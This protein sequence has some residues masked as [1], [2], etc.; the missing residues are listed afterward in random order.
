MLYLSR[1]PGEGIKIGDS[2]TVIVVR[3]PN[4]PS[5]IRLCIDSPVDFPVIKLEKAPHV[6]GVIASKDN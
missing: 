4:N 6:S 3:D 1:K 5:R 2:I